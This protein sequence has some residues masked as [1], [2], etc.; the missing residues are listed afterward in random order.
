LGWGMPYWLGIYQAGG[1]EDGFHAQLRLKNGT[2]VSTSIL[3]RPYTNGCIMLSD[4]DEKT[5]YDWAEIG[6]PVWIHY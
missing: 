3:G 2:T 5:L 4:Q 6:T 1:T